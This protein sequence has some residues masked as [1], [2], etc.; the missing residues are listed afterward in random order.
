MLIV[1]LVMY[2]KLAILQKTI[3]LARALILFLKVI[4]VPAL[5]LSLRVLNKYK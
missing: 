5:N 3:L 4:P 1:K 2:I